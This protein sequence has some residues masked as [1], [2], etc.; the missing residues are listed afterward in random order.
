MFKLLTILLFFPILLIAREIEFSWQAFPEAT[1]YQIQISKNRNFKKIVLE[2]KIKDPELKLKLEIG[3]YYY[4][5]RAYDKKDR[6]GV[7][8]KPVLVTVAPYPPKLLSP[9]KKANF[10]FYEKKNKII[11]KWQDLNTKYGYDILIQK[12]TGESV[13]S[14]KIEDISVLVDSLEAGEYTWKIR[15]RF[16]DKLI[17]PYSPPNYFTIS[18]TAL[19]P[20]LAVYPKTGQIVPAFRKG[21]FVWTK[22]EIAKFTDIELERTDAKEEIE[23]L[24]NIEKSEVEMPALMPGKYR[25]KITTKEERD[26]NGISSDWNAFRTSS[27]MLSSNN[28]QFRLMF[29]Y[30]IMNYQ[31]DSDRNGIIS[32][33]SNTSGLGFSFYTKIQLGS[34]FA[35]GLE[36]SK[37]TF[38]FKEQGEAEA[39]MNSLRLEWR[40]GENDFQQ[41][42]IL[43]YRLYDQFL[44]NSSDYFSINLYGPLLGTNMEGYLTERSKVSIQVLY[45]KPTDYFQGEGDLTVDYYDFKLRYAYNYLERIWLYYELSYEKDVFKLEE[46]GLDS[47]WSVDRL[48]PVNLGLSYEY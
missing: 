37:S 27:S 16:P 13:L 40:F 28:H 14:K 26:S 10:N 41:S 25:W 48:Y 43:G 19:K 20:P 7:W 6:G 42:F 29:N 24:Q 38:I 3:Q 17:S 33:N 1:A 4:R 44:L 22:D 11:F 45:F 34:Y 21:T 9:E 32:E 36:T 2:E 8:S 5:V 39:K 30:M 15:A 31:Y 18:Q 46:T 23:S 47:T 35:L 12:L